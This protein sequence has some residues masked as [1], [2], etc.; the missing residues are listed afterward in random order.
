MYPYIIQ[1]YL[2]VLVA[3]LHNVDQNKYYNVIALMHQCENHTANFFL[4]DI[5][6]GTY[7]KHWKAN[8]L[9]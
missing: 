3:I 1:E 7:C 9:Y 5:E 4:V 6:L 8:I 2:C